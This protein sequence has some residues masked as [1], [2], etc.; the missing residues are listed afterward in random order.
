LTKG[1]NQYFNWNLSNY[2]TYNEVFADIHDIE[3]TG[4]IETS[5]RS[6]RT[7]NNIQKNVNADSNYWS[8][9]GVNEVGNVISYRDEVFNETKLASYFGRFQYKLMDR[10]LL[11]G[12]IRRDGSSNFG[13]IWELF[14]PL[15]LMGSFKE[16]FIANV[17]ES[18]Y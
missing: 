1:R 17:K 18:I 7:T 13:I 12:T 3:L 8:L 14:Q 15:V 2:F 5:I 16:D 10:Y 4:G 6:K 11:T 9:S